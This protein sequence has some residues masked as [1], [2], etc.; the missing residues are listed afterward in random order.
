M[1]T[2]N[3]CIANC[4]YSTCGYASGQFKWI[5]SKEGSWGRWTY[6]EQCPRGYVLAG[7]RARSESNQGGSNDDT[8][9]RVFSSSLWFYHKELNNSLLYAVY[10]LWPMCRFWGRR[11]YLYRQMLKCNDIELIHPQLFLVLNQFTNSEFLL[12]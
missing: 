6:D 5:F 9:G 10:H 2:I 3:K 7:A 8:A 12:F 4:S 11:L 1:M